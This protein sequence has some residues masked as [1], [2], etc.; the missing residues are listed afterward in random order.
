MTRQVC[1]LVKPTLKAKL[2][3]SVSLDSMDFLI[4]KLANATP[5]ALKMQLLVMPMVNVLASQ[6]SLVRNAID[7]LMVTT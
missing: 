1:A 7:A 4:V 2:V 3:T 6:I 5:K